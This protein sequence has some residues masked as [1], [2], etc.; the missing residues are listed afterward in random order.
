ETAE[1]V[2]ML[3]HLTGGRFAFGV[4]AGWQPSGVSAL[5]GPLEGGLARPGGGAGGEPV[6]FPGRHFPLDD[7]QLTLLPRQRPRPPI[8]MG[9]NSAAA[10]VRRAARLADAWIVSA[11]PDLDTAERHAGLYRG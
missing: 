6:T 9:A 4:G 11:P 8:W 5:G 7:V 3:D 2:A 1:Q 10:A